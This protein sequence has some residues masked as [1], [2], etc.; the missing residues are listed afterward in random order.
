MLKRLDGKI[1]KVVL[2][3]ELRILH[4][5]RKQQSKKVCRTELLNLVYISFRG[6]DVGA[7]GIV[8]RTG[9][10]SKCSPSRGVIYRKRFSVF[11]QLSQLFVS[12]VRN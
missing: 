9:A 4:I 12:S 5:A 2:R 8:V 11:D 1:L 10:E 3:K 6:E 7:A